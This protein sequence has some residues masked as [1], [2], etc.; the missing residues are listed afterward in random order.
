MAPSQISWHWLKLFPSICIFKWLLGQFFI[1]NFPLFSQFEKL[2]EE[3]EMKS[4][5]SPTVIKYSFEEIYL[6]RRSSTSAL[7]VR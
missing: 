1:F 2:S 7:F 6:S 5:K 4:L 3:P